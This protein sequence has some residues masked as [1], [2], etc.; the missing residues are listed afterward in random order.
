MM[1][2]RL[3]YKDGG[4]GAWTFDKERIYKVAEFFRAYV[5]VVDV[6]AD[7]GYITTWNG[8]VL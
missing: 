5:E 8:R 2:Y 4:V 7:T 6:E 1:K 3:H